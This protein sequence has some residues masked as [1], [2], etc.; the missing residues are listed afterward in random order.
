MGKLSDE[1]GAVMGITKTGFR[2]IRIAVVLLAF[3]ILGGCAGKAVKYSYITR[4]SFQEL[5]SYQWG[6]ANGL[7]RQDPKME[8]YVQF[9]VDRDLEL[10]GLVKKTGMA[11]LWIW[12]SYEYDSDSTSNKLQMLSL[13]ISRTDTSELVWQGA[14][15]GGI[16]TDGNTSELMKSLETI[17]A[18]F[19]PR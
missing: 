11:D 13:N 8:A 12:I 17:L 5:K 18:N 7:Y 1:G 15:V 3:L 19:P 2:Y 9:Q 14:A 6:K 4:A 10:K 16:R